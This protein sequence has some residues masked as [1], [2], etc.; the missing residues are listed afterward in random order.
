[1]PQ[2]LRFSKG[3]AGCRSGRLPSAREEAGLPR[4]RKREKRKRE[5]EGGELRDGLGDGLGEGEGEI[6]GEGEGEGEG[7]V[8]VCVRV[9]VHAGYE[10]FR[11]NEFH[12]TLGNLATV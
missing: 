12:P 4:E 7:W 10:M 11:N 2:K 1:M 5:R 6:E 3:P 9:C 8:I